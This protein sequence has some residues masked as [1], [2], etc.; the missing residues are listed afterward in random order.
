MAH[1]SPIFDEPY[2]GIQVN[3]CVSAECENFGIS[4]PAL[5]QDVKNDQNLNIYFC[6]KCGSYPQKIDNKAVYQSVQHQKQYHGLKVI[7]CPHEQCGSHGF[8]VH[9][10]MDKYRSF[11]KTNAL[12]KRYQCRECKCVFTDRFSGINTH[13]ELQSALFYGMKY[14]QGVR[15][16]CTLEGITPKAFYTHQRDMVDRLK[17]LAHVKEYQFFNTT[18]ECHLATGYRYI[19]K[20][21]GAIIVA[22]VHNQSGYVLGFDTNISKKI[23]KSC[24]LD[25]PKSKRRVR[26]SPIEEKG[27]LMSLILAGYDEIMSRTN[28]LDPASNGTVMDRKPLELT[29]P[30]LCSFAHALVMHR[31]LKYKSQ[32]YY[33]VEQETMLRNAFINASLGK[34]KTQGAQLFYY[35]ESIEKMEWFDKDRLHVKNVGW[36]QDKWGFVA[37][38]DGTKG[39]CHIKGNGLTLE[40]WKDLTVETSL[41]DVTRYLDLSSSFLRTLVN[42]VN[43]QSINDWL[44]IFTAYYNY[45][46]PKKNGKTPAQLMGFTDRAMGLSEL[47]SGEYTIRAR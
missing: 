46:I 14:N 2:K 8:A 17:Y 3:Y 28:Y 12:K 33:F 44:H 38:P 27:D 1:N 6:P 16:L 7:S 20:A 26:V 39:A 29:Q 4:D 15:N 22:S 43:H 42:T 11:G 36:W 18:D 47:L 5:Y 45:C 19:N 24:L 13:L 37:M 21:S 32:L 34:L 31:K 41:N 40:K 9:T 10:H 35:K 30:Y 25:K 23:D